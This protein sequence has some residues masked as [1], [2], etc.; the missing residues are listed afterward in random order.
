[1]GVWTRVKGGLGAES[2]RFAESFCASFGGLAFEAS[3]GASE[4]VEAMT[5]KMRACREGAGLI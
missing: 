1:M 2:G 5:V 4:K 3:P